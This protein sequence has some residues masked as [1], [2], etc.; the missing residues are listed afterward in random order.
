MGAQATASHTSR[1]A[2][3]GPRG[4]GLASGACEPGHPEIC[5][6]NGVRARSHRHRAHDTR[7]F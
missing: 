5:V 6:K 4:S 2:V 3:I 1:T 7:L